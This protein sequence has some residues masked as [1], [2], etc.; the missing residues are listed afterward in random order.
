MVGGYALGA[1]APPATHPLFAIRSPSST[2][3]FL[4]ASAGVSDVGV[5]GGTTLIGSEPFAEEAELAVYPERLQTMFDQHIIR[6][7]DTLMLEDAGPHGSDPSWYREALR[8]LVA[9]AATRPALTVLLLTTPSVPPAPLGCQWDAVFGGQSHN[10]AIR[11][12]AA[13]PWSCD[14]VL[15]DWA[16]AFTPHHAYA[17]GQWGIPLV[18]ADGIHPNVWGQ[19]LMVRLILE[20]GSLLPRI[21]TTA[22]L[23]ALLKAN[24]PL[25]AYGSP[26]C[27]D[28]CVDDLVTRIVG[29]PA[30][31]TTPRRHRSACS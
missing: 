30:R 29:V 5:G 27:T 12:V 23:R 15:V 2:L 16:V 9:V 17:L 18:H 25:V 21:T 1:A 26:N 3:R 20:Y 10:D 24:K 13:E 8:T 7:G 22:P 11:A 4:L 14:V 19:L 6:D 31:S 28:Q